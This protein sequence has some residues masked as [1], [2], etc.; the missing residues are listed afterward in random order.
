[1]GSQTLSYTTLSLV[2]QGYKKNWKRL[3][4]LFYKPMAT[5]ILSVE[6]SGEGSPATKS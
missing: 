2:T 4:P 5:K 6:V 3:Y 1:M